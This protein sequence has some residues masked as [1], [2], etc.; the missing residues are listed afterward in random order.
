[1]VRKMTGQKCQFRGD[2]YLDRTCRIPV[3]YPGYCDRWRPF[4]AVLRRDE[5]MVH[6]DVL[7]P[8]RSTR[9]LSLD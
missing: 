1:M 2:P 3:V 5:M 9:L 6:I 8:F 4:L 7:G